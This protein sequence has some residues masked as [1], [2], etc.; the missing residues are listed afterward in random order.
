MRP[1]DT[2]YLLGLAAIWG[3]SFLFM[4]II[5]P[6]IGTVPTAFF[7]V[8]SY[9]VGMPATGSDAWRTFVAEL[10]HAPE[11]IA[12]LLAAH[13]PDERGLCRGCGSPGR[14]SPYRRWPCALFQLAQ[15][16]RGTVDE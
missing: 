1:V 13:R 6:E 16:A 11:A 2:L 5:A 10:A 15:A 4:R 14:G 12:L 3:A 7:R 9:P 8:S